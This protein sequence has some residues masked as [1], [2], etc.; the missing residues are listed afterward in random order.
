[1]ETTLPESIT[2]RKDKVG[3][4]PPQQLWM[5]HP[6]WQEAIREARKKLVDEKILKENILSKPVIPM[7]SYAADNFD[8]RYLSAAAFL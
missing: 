7:G 1:M 4:E 5:R 3:F 6:M 8:W 2:W